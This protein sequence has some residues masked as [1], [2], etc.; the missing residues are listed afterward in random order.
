MLKVL[1]KVLDLISGKGGDRKT[2]MSCKAMPILWAL[3]LFKVVELIILIRA[4]KR[5][6]VMEEK[7]Q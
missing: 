1:H 3:Y 6:L 2:M 5:N 4:R 7:K